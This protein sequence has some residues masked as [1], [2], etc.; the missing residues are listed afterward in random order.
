MPLHQYESKKEHLKN[1]VNKI[2]HLFFTSSPRFWTT[3]KGKNYF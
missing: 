1:N 2:I 3:R